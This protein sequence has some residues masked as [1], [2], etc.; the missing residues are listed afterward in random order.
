M[1]PPITYYGGKIGMAERIIELMPSHRVYIEPF[2]G[3]GAVFFA[4]PAVTHEIVNDVDGAV[5]AFFR[6]LRERPED[7]AQVCRLTPYAREEYAAADCDER[8]L[9]DL[10]RARRFWV[11]VNQSFAKTAGPRTGWSITTARTQSVCGSV[12]GRLDRF[13]ACAERLSQVA[14]ESCDGADLIERLATADTVVY[15]DP[16]YLGTTRSGMTKRGDYRCEMGDRE[17]H[18]RLAEVLHQTPATVILSGYPSPLYEDLY[19]DWPRLDT[20]VLA[21]SSNAVTSERG[22]RTE[23]LWMNRELDRGL[24]ATAVQRPGTVTERTDWTSDG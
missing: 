3:S 13:A 23:V 4:K 16:P 10:E 18:E 6:V 22:D 19:G 20:A 5:V 8:G 24:F 2:F 11:R 15:V 7:L 21:H 14:I 1:R 17:D 12:A 9:D